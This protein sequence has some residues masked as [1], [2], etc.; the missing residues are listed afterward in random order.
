MKQYRIEVTETY[1]YY[2]DVEAAD[3][4]DAYELALDQCREEN[5]SRAEL[6]DREAIRVVCVKDL[7]PNSE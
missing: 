4:F 6:I 7:E 2:I 3:K 5:V 1:S